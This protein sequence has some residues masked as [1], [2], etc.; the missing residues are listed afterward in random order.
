MIVKANLSDVDRIGELIVVAMKENY[1]KLLPCRVKTSQLVKQ[2]ISSG[3]ALALM[4]EEGV[5]LAI[6]APYPCAERNHTQ[7]VVLWA[8]TEAVCS[9]L[10]QGCL[11]WFEP[12]K[13]ST[14]VEYASAET[15]IADEVLLNAGFVNNG[16]MLVKWRY[17]GT[18][19]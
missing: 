2:C 1:P 5:M 18:S 9:E 7:I 19:K 15:S 13:G 14:M 3:N 17:N 16:T 6:E 4:S 10:L 12:R 11:E 8:S